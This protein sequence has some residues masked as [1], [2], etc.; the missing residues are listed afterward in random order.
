MRTNQWILAVI[1]LVLVV[2]S[3]SVF[4]VMQTQT[5]IL[6]QLGKIQTNAKGQ[7]E[8]LQPGLHFKLP[9]VQTVQRF[10]MRLRT[11]DIESS[12]IMTKEQKE[13][14]V[15]AFVKW[16]INDPV[17]YY[18]ATSANVQTAESLLQQQ[19]NAGMRGAFGKQTIADLLSEDRNEVMAQILQS[20]KQSAESIGVQV[21]DVRIKRIDLPTEVAETIYQRMSSARE[22]MASLIRA[23][24]QQQAEVIK[25]KADATVAVTIAKAKSEAASIRAAGEAE[26]A[27]IYADAYNKDP[28]FYAFY[29]SLAAYQSV[30]GAHHNTVVLSPKGQFFQYFNAMGNISQGR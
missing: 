17:Q 24:G 14:L 9:L 3:M 12:R 27:K 26:A 7:P 5:A 11:L 19:L 15:D 22:K 29:R 28:N 6:I 1:V 10:D 23:E 16:R 30:F 25:A 8:I 21:V 4:T 20:V 13:V 18:K 2:A